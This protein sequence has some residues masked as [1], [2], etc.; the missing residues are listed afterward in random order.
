MIS[1]LPAGS[2][3]KSH[4]HES[5]RINKNTAQTTSK[6]PN[7]NRQATSLLTAGP[8]LKEER[9][10]INAIAE[11]LGRIIERKQSEV[12]LKE[13]EKSLKEA[14]EIAHLGQW[15]LDL[16]SNTLYWSDGIYRIFEIDPDKFGASFETFLDSVHP[17]DRDYVN[18]AYIDSLKNKTPYNIIHR[19][20]LKDGTIKYVNEICR[21]EYDQDGNPLYSFGTVQDINERVQA[22]KKIE[23]YSKNL[24]SMVE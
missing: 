15:K 23:E 20:L 5:S 9:D 16:V 19:L 10:L 7:G 2:I 17:E 12:S 21:T 13:S 18:K 11:R 3:R 22:E 8:F 1:F 6:K 4:A 14:H 24:E